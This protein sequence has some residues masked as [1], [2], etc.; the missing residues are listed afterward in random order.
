MQARIIASLLG[1]FLVGCISIDPETGAREHQ[2]YQ[3]DYVSERADQLEVGMGK[4]TVLQ[5]LGSPA[6]KSDDGDVWVYLP[7]R[8]AVIIPGRALHLEFRNG[9]LIE[10]GFR[11]IIL[12]QEL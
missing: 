6:E 5:L 9:A 2:R 10:H 8:P 7:E 3:F 1:L 12:G 11:A 4:T